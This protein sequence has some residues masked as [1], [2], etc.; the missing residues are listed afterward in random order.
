M[1]IY[2]TDL[3]LK[4]PDGDLRRVAKKGQQSILLQREGIAYCKF[5]AWLGF[6]PIHQEKRHKSH[7]ETSFINRL[8]WPFQTKPHRDLQQVTKWRVIL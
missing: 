4:G 1:V 8:L 5:M 6:A 3:Q 2:R 7:L